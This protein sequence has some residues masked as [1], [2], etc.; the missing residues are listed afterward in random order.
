MKL[1]LEQFKAIVRDS[2][3]VSLD[4]LLINEREELLVGRRMHRPAQGYLFVPGG[5]VLKGETL[6]A[7]LGRIVL[8]ETG[9]IVAPGQFVFHGIYDHVYS[10]SCF[11]D[12]D[13]STQYVV[14]A[15]RC[16]ISS[17]VNIVS[18]EQHKD[19][20]F[21]PITKIVSDAQVHP[22]VKNYFC[23]H[24][25]NMFLGSVAEASRFSKS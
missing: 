1:P 19:L 17:D 11:N 2:V 8:Q 20:H 15:C 25:E 18:D 13:I 9:L 10:E 24:A 12:A 7:A 23:L 6:S 16:S 5:R 21:M 14:I 3:L 4:V 22:Y